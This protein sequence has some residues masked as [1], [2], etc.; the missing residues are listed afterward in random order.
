MKKNLLIVLLAA[1]VSSTAV[2]ANAVKTDNKK[3][4]IAVSATAGVSNT[5]DVK[6][7]KE[8]INCLVN[9]LHEIR[10][11]DKAKLSTQDKRA[12][13][14][15]VKDIK[16]ILKQQDYVLYISLTALLIILLLIIL[17]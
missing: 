6:M 7:S 13:R 3:E 15:E 17:L 9:R 1:F 14:Q 11:M 8:E 10:D 4:P 5:T 16:Q 12:L 2:S